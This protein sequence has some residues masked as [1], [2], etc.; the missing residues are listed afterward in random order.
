MVPASA[1]LGRL[2]QNWGTHIALVFCEMWETTNLN[3][4]CPLGSKARR[5]KTVV[6]HIS[7]KTSAIWAPP[8]LLQ[9]KTTQDYAGTALLCSARRS[10]IRASSRVES[11]VGKG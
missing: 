2:Q 6:S 9:R 8:V 1:G 3:R 4:T 11:S 7:Q 10:A 5:S